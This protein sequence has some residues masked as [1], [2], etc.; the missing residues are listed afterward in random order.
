[1]TTIESNSRI[2][3]WLQNNKLIKAVVDEDKGCIIVYDEDDNI[4]MKRSELNKLQ[5]REIENN[6]K[7]YGARKLN[8]TAEPFRFL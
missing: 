1:M 4:I 6:I 2:W 8:A 5:I 7:R 3:M